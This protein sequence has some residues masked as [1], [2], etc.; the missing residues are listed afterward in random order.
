LTWNAALLPQSIGIGKKNCFDYSSFS[1][2]MYHGHCSLALVLNMNFLVLHFITE[3]DAGGAQTALYRLLKHTD[4][5]GIKPVVVCLYN[6]DRLMADRIRQLGVPVIDVQLTAWWRIDALWRLYRLLRRERPSILHCWLFHANFLGRI[7][8]RLARVP[9]IITSRRNVEIGG[10]WRERLQRGTVEL[11]DKIIA[12]CEAARQAEIQ[13]SHVS[14]DKVVTI[15]NGIDVAPF[16][17]STRQAIRRELGID[18]DAFL[19]G[20]IGRLHRQK[21]HVYLFQ[22]LR[23]VRPQ[24][25]DVRLLVVGDCRL[26][27]ELVAQAEREGVADVVIFTGARGD[28]PEILSALD[29][30]VLP[31]LWEGLPNVVLEAMAAGLP[32]VATAVGGTPELII[33]G[34][35]GLLVPPQ[36]A[37][38]LAQ[39]ILHLLANPE[40]ANAMGRAGRM[41]VQSKFAM[42]HSTLATH[43]LYHDL[44]NGLS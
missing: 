25:A 1:A 31:S 26:R 15:Y 8:G 23:Q 2:L 6:G 19:L 41:H 30:F 20:V 37:D 4:L 35:T 43:Q 27:N 9:I 32:V 21:G 17:V 40:Q 5:T 42:S 18:A 34:E 14:P 44:I 24:F 13:R 33:N 7:M 29:L 11:D 39:A 12:V 28:I 22:A 36:D 16:A 38:S 3:L 10:A